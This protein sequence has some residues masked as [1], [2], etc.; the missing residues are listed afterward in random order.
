MGYTR[1]AFNVFGSRLSSV[2]LYSLV[3]HRNVCFMAAWYGSA[4]PRIGNGG[5][6]QFAFFTSSVCTYQFNVGS[7]MLAL[8]YVDIFLSWLI[9]GS[10]YLTEF[11]VH[12]DFEF[13]RRL[14]SLLHLVFAVPRSPL[15]IFPVMVLCINRIF[16]M[17]GSVLCSIVI[18]PLFQPVLCL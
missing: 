10:K 6:R 5:H 17:H 11:P 18:F 14:T 4:K 13:S 8:C 9:C 3:Y 15:L 16:S 1:F 2:R 7:F 12:L